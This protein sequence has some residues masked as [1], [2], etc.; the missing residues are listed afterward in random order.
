MHSLC[1]FCPSR[2]F[3]GQKEY[4]VELQFS[5]GLTGYPDRVKTG[6]E[7]ERDGEKA[8][9]GSSTDVSRTTSMG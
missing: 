4:E 2:F 9:V 6:W 8:E 1:L 3:A 7:E 5:S